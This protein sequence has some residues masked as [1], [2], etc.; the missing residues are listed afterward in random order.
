MERL[1]FNNNIIMTKELEFTLRETLVIKHTHIYIYINKR[2]KIPG[3]MFD[4]I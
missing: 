1:K 4:T 3:K 2:K